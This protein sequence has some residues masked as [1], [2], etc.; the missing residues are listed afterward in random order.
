MHLAIGIKFLAYW[1]RV[2]IVLFRLPIGV[3]FLSD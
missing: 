2:R 3:K 1:T